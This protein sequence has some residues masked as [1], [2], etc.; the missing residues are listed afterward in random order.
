MILTIIG[1][2]IGL[3]AFARKVVKNEPLKGQIDSIIDTANKIL[4]LYKDK[5][6]QHLLDNLLKLS[7][8]GFLYSLILCFFILQLPERF[9]GYLLMLIA[10]FLVL[11]SVLS[12]S[13]S[14]INKHNKTFKEI[15]LNIQMIGLLFLPTIIHLLN[16]YLQTNGLFSSVFYPF[17]YIIANWGLIYFQ[18]FWLIGVFLIFYLGMMVI[19]LPTYFII[20]TL[21]FISAYIIRI[22]EKYIDGH[23]M[24][25]IVGLISVI[26]LF[27]K[28]FT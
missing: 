25:G 28:L 26:V 3:Y 9:T 17:H 22:L 13:I 5:K 1:F 4:S 21:I 23:I 7:N 16:S 19:A 20:Y 14:W 8:N 12:L 6:T 11:C 24:D 2:L 15:F 18:V 27:L 10:P